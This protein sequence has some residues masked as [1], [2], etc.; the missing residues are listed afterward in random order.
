MN[1]IRDPTVVAPSSMTALE[2]DHG[3]EKSP[4]EPHKNAAMEHDVPI[5]FE[6]VFCLVVREPHC[7]DFHGWW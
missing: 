7:H 4:V 2:F 6:S 1:Y 5:L 3:R